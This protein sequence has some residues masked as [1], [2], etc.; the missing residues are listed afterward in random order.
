[1]ASNRNSDQDNI[2]FPLNWRKHKFEKAMTRNDGHDGHEGCGTYTPISVANLPW[3]HLLSHLA[4]NSG[5]SVN[6]APLSA[7]AAEYSGK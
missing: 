6:G 7:N 3:A 4:S 1:M 2:G 5:A